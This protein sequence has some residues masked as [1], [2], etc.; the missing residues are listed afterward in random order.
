MTAELLDA[1]WSGDGSLQRELPGYQI[2]PG[3]V[4]MSR[5]V[6]QALDDG[7][8]RVI[9]A[10]TGI[11]KT[12]AYLAP[13]LLGS[14]RVLVS[15]ATLALQ[16][17]LIGRDLPALQR[18]LGVRRDVAL[19][20]G[21]GRYLCR[22]RFMQS[23]QDL[24]FSG[25][26][27]L[28]RIRPWMEQTRSGD[29]SECATLSHDPDLIAR[30]TASGDNCL[31]QECPEFR[32]CHVV[33]A[34]RAAMDAEVV[35]VNHHLLFADMAL[36]EDGFGELLPGADAIVVD[37]AHQIRDVASQFFGAAV[38]TRQMGLLLRDLRSEVTALGA[39]QPDLLRTAEAVDREARSLRGCLPDAEQRIAYPPGGQFSVPF[40]DQRGRLQGALQLLAAGLDP[41]ADRSPGLNQ[42]MRRARHLSDGLAQWGAEQ[43]DR[44]Q[45]HWM[46]TARNA[47]VFHSTPLEVGTAL[48]AFRDRQPCPWIFTSA[49][50]T[51]AARFSHF[52]RD[53]GLDENTPCLKLASPFD[54]ARQALTYVPPDLPLP[55]APEYDARFLAAVRPVL[56]WSGGRAFL[57]F[58]SH[59]A[60]RHAAAALADLP[61]PVLT[62]GDAP[63][64]RLLERFVAAG[65]A[66]LLGAA[67][68]WAGVDVRGEALQLVAIDRL[69]FAALDDPVLQARI[70][71]AENQGGN[72]FREVQLPAAVMALRQGA[73]RLIRDAHDRGVLLVGD[74]RLLE[75]PYG[76][77]FLDSLPPTPVT[78]DESRVAAFFRALRANVGDMID[79]PAGD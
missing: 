74:R 52:L 44:P 16:D 78:R 50:L 12:F 1:F 33:K 25:R 5:W 43:G 30:I 21:R 2:R 24:W 76:R 3:Q 23:E 48:R 62:Q 60:L 58:T 35:V 40:A 8:T 65:N 59:R 57:L 37:E 68:F 14:Q 72:A 79:A 46:H 20:K 39:D 32:N 11:G 17:Q 26:A 4:E 69:P 54:Y 67:G 47:L 63:P 19:L 49:T 9:E 13:V 7:Q 31:G 6:Q 41:V 51:V 56:E 10:G 18:A 70:K 15:T 77:A 42:L 71:A 36:R 75:R 22:Y 34:R 45:V 73:G 55:N 29:L 28:S 38:S 53:V 66:V 64:A 61:F 27:A